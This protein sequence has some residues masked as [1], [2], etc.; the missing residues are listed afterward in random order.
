MKKLKINLICILVIFFSVG[1]IFL[2]CDEIIDSD[3]Y[4]IKYEVD[5]DTIHSSVKLDVL[6]TDEDTNNLAFI[7]DARVPW[8]T[9]IGPVKKGFNANLEVS[10]PPESSDSLT[11]YVQISVSKNNGPFALKIYDGSE[12]PRDSVQ[13]NYKVE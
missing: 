1:F 6:I 4:Y 7:I 3:E 10:C 8:E 5:S 13:I 9:I 12:T 2:C 11:L